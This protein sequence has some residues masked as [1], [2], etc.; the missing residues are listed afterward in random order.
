MRAHLLAALLG[1]GLAALAPAAAS[2]GD[3]ATACVAAS[4]AV[5]RASRLPP[6]LLNAIGIVET[7][8]IDPFRHVLAPWPWSVN[9]N[10]EGHM[11][12]SKSQAIAAVLQ[13]RAA[14]IDSIDVGCMQVNLHHHPDAFASL[15]EAFDPFANTAYA[16]RFL[17]QL[18]EQTGSWPTAA[19]AYH[20]QTPSLGEPYEARVMAAWPD[21]GRYGG[22]ALP[23]VVVDPDH[24]LTPAFRARLRADAALRAT[25][26]AAMHG[27]KYQAALP[28]LAAR[29]RFGPV[30]PLTGPYPAGWRAAAR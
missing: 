18:F 2:Y 25:R 10:G 27:R 19:A 22:A 3:D 13:F 7:G 12:D 20:S 26:E 30:H 24:V 16:A 23:L 9:A 15:E 4:A 29:F 17:A 21:A 14:G 6:R 11:Y 8:R 1:L 28:S 5:Q